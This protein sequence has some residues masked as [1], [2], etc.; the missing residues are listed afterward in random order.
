MLKLQETRDISRKSG[1]LRN[2][3][4]FIYSLL[5]LVGIALIIYLIRDF[6]ETS[7]DYL[8]LQEKSLDVSIFN[9][10][11][12]FMKQYAANISK[13]IEDNQKSD[14]YSETGVRY[15]TKAEGK[16][17]TD[18]S[19]NPLGLPIYDG[20]TMSGGYF[21]VDYSRFHDMSYPNEYL[22]GLGDFTNAEAKNGVSVE[23][24]KSDVT[25][26]GEGTKYLKSNPYVT[27]IGG[28]WCA[29]GR[30]CVAL[31]A[32]AITRP[33]VHESVIDSY[34][35]NVAAY[36]HTDKGTKCLWYIA[37]IF[38]DFLNGQY[39]DC[40]LADGT[41]IA[42]VVTDTKGAHTGVYNNQDICEDNLVDGYCHRRCFLNG[43][44]SYNG[45]LEFGVTPARNNDLKSKTHFNLVDNK[46]V[47]FRVYTDVKHFNGEKPVEYFNYFS[48]GD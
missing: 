14:I 44:L 22:R 7:E 18:T 9:S 16:L 34:W 11:A 15:N 38:S 12:K 32:G 29:D 23:F 8:K 1:W 4:I 46:I 26:G 27:E 5:G 2:F 45:I 10:K 47:G 3:K 28:Y 24:I 25:K 20:Y 43:K 17:I 33:E 36:N 6:N 35:R 37:G 40:V 31:P 19:I 30:V 13:Q 39:V 42:L 48:G 41:V 21:D